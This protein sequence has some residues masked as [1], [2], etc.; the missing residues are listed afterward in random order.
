M[1]KKKEMMICTKRREC[2]FSKMCKHAA[3]HEKIHH[4]CDDTAGCNCK[5]VPLEKNED[6]LLGAT[7]GDF[8]HI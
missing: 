1:D 3:S 2:G 7:N 6:L 8:K 5:C 4:Q